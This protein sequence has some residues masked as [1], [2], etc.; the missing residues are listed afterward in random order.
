MY[1]YGETM[2]KPKKLL[3]LLTSTLAFSTAVAAKCPTGSV[4]VHGKVDNL[5]STA[6]GAEATVVVETAKGNV[7]RTALLS[8]GEFTVEV[9]FSTHS[10]STWLGGDRCHTV[11]KFVEVKIVSAGKV[12]IQKRLNFKDSFEVTKFYEY[13]LKQELSL[14]V[15]KG[16]GNGNRGQTGRSLHLTNDLTDLRYIAILPVGGMRSH[17]RQK[18]CISPGV[19]KET[20]IYLSRTGYLGPIKMLAFLRCSIT[21]SGERMGFTMTKFVCESMAL[22]MRALT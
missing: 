22:S 17:T 15:P 4:T 12:Y 9:P 19:P 11:P 10:S 21:S 7:E 16:S 5:P 3:L 8:N 18:A 6:T 20:R 1:P 2:R 14:D 13:R